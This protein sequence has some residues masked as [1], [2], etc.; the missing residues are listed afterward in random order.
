M[1]AAVLKARLRA[2]SGRPEARLLL[3]GQ[4]AEHGA[5]IEAV[6][7]IAAAARD[8][9]PEAQAR[10]GVCYLR[11][12]GVPACQSEARFWLERAADGGDASARTELASL[13]LSGVSGPYNRGPFPERDDRKEPNYPLAA[14]LARQAARAGSAEAKAL[15]A[16]ILRLAPWAAEAG[17][18]PVT[19][20]RD[21]AQAGWPLG[22]LGY[23]MAMMARG[24]EEATREANGLLSAAA[25]SGLPTAHFL[26]GAMAETGTGMAPDMA[27]AVTHYRAAAEHGHAGAR[28]RLGLALLTG[29]GTKRNLTEAE[30]WLR[31]AA[32]SG[33]ALA[34]A[35]LGDFHASAERDPPHLEEAAHWYRLAAEHGYPGAA[36]L[37][38]RI[39]ANG[40]EGQPDP[41]EIAAW[42]ET[43]IER[44]ETGA[45]PELGG[46][47]GSAAL[48]PG[49][50]PSL[51][52]W[53]QR[54]I[55][56]DRPEAGFYVGMCVN[57][58]IGTPPRRE[59]GA[60]VLPV[61]RGRGGDRKH[62]RGG[63]DAAE[64]PRREAGACAGSGVVRICRETQ[65]RGRAVRAGRHGRGRSGR[66]DGLFPAGGGAGASEGAT[67]DGRSSGR[68]VMRG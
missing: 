48:P 9:Y 23:A 5:G 64:R 12:L 8:G 46:L 38:A 45:W 30:T 32:N 3:A 36:R 39:I 27:A 50:L 63:G 52:G 6:R 59:A 37:L 4:L 10:L 15:L 28:T 22:Q 31:R 13:A 19:L 61:G 25:D 1:P 2:A 11:G 62:G 16:A 60:A 24:T 34:A 55:R 56:E 44:G 7:H 58:G 18:D 29:R 68:G 17:D 49:Q 67:Y 41:T 33:E 51:H 66:R 43:A 21:S 65:A 35:A 57:N 53:L 40:V 54:M 47:I 20:N 42:L 26:F 14:D